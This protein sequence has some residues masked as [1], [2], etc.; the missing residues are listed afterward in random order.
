[1]IAPVTIKPQKETVAP[2]SVIGEDEEEDDEEP[3]MAQVIAN[4][5]SGVTA[6]PSTAAAPSTLG[7]KY[8]PNYYRVMQAASVV[9]I[10]DSSRI[11]LRIVEPTKVS[12][13][14]AGP[15]IGLLPEAIDKYFFQDSTSDKFAERLDIVSKLKPT[16]QGFLRVG[17]DN[18][19]KAQS[20]LAAVAPF[21]FQ[22]N[23]EKVIENILEPI[24]TRIPVK[25]FLQL[26]GG[27]L[28][29]E[30]FNRCEKKHTNEMRNWAFIHLG[31]DELR[32]SN[33]PA[34]ERLMNSY[35]CF[36]DYI[37]D[38]TEK[39]DVRTFFNAFSDPK[40]MPPR[41][42]IFIILEATVEEISI[43]KGEKVEFKKEVLLENVRC[44]PYP[45]SQDQQKAD[46]GFIIHYNKITRDRYKRDQKTYTHLGWDPLFYVDGNLPTAESR[47]KPT[48]F[49]QRSQ[50]ATWPPVVQR[51]VSEFFSKC[52]AVNRG[53]FTSQFGFYPN[54]LIPAQ[55][56][57]TAIRIQPAGIIRD[58]YNHLVGVGYRLPGSKKTGRSSTIVA[59]P[60]ADD[61]SMYFESKVFFDWDDFDPAPA[62]ALV[63]FY[64][65]HINNIFPQYKGYI[66]LEI[67]KSTDTDQIIGVGLTNSFV[68]PSSEPIDSADIAGMVSRGINELEWDIN[69]TIAYDSEMRIEAFKDANKDPGKDEVPIVD[70]KAKPYLKLKMESYQDE[71]EDVYQHLRLS[72]STWLATGAGVEKRE[73]LEEILKIKNLPLSD[74]RKRL[75]ILLY[76]DVIR[77]LE[78]KESDEKSDIGF[79]RID[80]QIQGQENCK[81]RC[82]W[83]PKASDDIS[84]G[85]CKIHTP[86]PAQDADGVIMN[87]PRMLYLRLVDEL[88]RY[89]A[90]RK[91]IFNGTVP[92]LTIR[93]EAQRSGD[94][95][96]IPE[97]SADWNTW[98]EMLRVEW[99]NPDIE[100]KKFFDEQY[101]PIPT[102]IPRDD[103]RSLPASLKA[104][105]G[106]TD[107]K[108]DG[109]V[110]NPSTI[111]DRPF[112]FL[113]E[114]L[115][116]NPI[117]SKAEKTLDIN[118]LKEIGKIGMTQILWMPSGQIAGS[119]RTKTVG[120]TSA[121]II[122]NVDG[123]VGWVSQ[124]GA[125]GVKIPLNALP[126]SL[127]AFR[128]V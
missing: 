26:N 127:N 3:A 66:P 91:E 54:A 37:I 102:G 95:Y 109:L 58:A 27:N 2:L 41:G 119:M 84:C 57:V 94:Q 33:I 79:L 120:A 118:E 126:E 52:N 9:R 65:T 128:L 15:Q 23:A 42:I 32:S 97:G 44:P 20:F 106:P 111:E 99:M 77:W 8:E 63:E 121:I 113:K 96:I 69:N 72:F 19:D 11:P 22:P 6:R 98:W 80:C 82:K 122:A 5:I 17:I 115:R 114:I 87:V 21:F 68:V 55:D 62:D 104:A 45:I 70:P 71:I 56:I 35:E 1:V 108:V 50:E 124:K 61:G 93:R 125:Y 110:W 29:H 4:T 12:D 100:D 13:P 75:D 88:I 116:F 73:R 90:K 39:K 60:V 59:V 28:V 107:P 78:P 74:K 43:R 49:F 85:P 40:V 123:T 86:K 38:P 47:H 16:A 30:F 46:I 117:A 7:V 92:R 25:K 10:I 51:R 67:R 48:L 18:S 53:P 36:K 34:I 101:E 83:A 24:E 105:L 89:A 64:K 31:I 81:G 112:W 14:K 103:N 76:N